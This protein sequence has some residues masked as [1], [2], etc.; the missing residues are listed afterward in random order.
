[1]LSDV[2]ADLERQ[3][4]QLRA[5]LI[6]ERRAR[7][8][9]S[10]I[11]VL[12]AQTTAEISRE[13]VARVIADGAAQIFD[14]GWA[15]VA[16]V[17]D[18]TTVRFVHGPGVPDPIA[19]D[20]REAPLDTAV[21]ICDVLRG[22]A[23]RIELTS[24]AE[25][26]PWPIMIAE[27]ERA[28]MSSLMVFRMGPGHR[29]S[30][31][32]AMAWSDGHVLDDVERELLALLIEQ[33]GAGFI[34]SER[35]EV[36]GDVAHALQGALL[37]DEPV[38]VDGL[39]ISVLYEPGKD[40]LAVGGDWYDVIPI[41]GVGTAVVIGDVVGHDVHAAIEMT[42]IRHV[43]ATHLVTLRDP[44]AALAASDAYVRRRAPQ[45]MATVLVVVIA[46]DGE[47]TLCSAGH[48]PPISV[49]SERAELLPVGLGPPIG[50]GLGDYSSAMAHVDP[51]T[52]I[53][54]FT[55][56]I[57]ETRSDPLDSS[58]VELQDSLLQVARATPIDTS[59]TAAI[60]AALSK[61]ADVSW[62]ID[63]AAAV[64]VQLDAD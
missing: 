10:D 19:Q 62:R 17:A 7:Q 53:V 37:E 64:I 56:G 49:T 39:S 38:A 31:V 46:A 8:L 18:E 33:A 43:V 28:D 50:S 48:L 42:Q 36:D 26:A 35:T 54:A 24:R 40:F 13:G 14:A 63:D 9:R 60:T 59:M 30:A 55:D 22:E 16:Y 52:V 2:E 47:L 58:L 4:V 15:M 61:R 29:P 12:A 25:F 45:V 21:P 32:L 6:R 57:V 44:V 23:D 27:A 11:G 5:E 41:E 1:V 20:W 34:R 51:G 3:I